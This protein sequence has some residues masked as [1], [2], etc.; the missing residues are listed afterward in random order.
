MSPAF[1]HALLASQGHLDAP[2]VPESLNAHHGF[3]ASK[4]RTP[5]LSTIVLPNYIPE[6]PPPLDPRLSR[7]DTPMIDTDPEDS[8]LDDVWFRSSPI[9]PTTVKRA[10]K[11][12]MKL[13]WVGALLGGM[14]TVSMWFIAMSTLITVL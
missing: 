12:S 10:K 5:T 6:P 4:A 7:N 13:F 11:Q 3:I 9:A 14:L 8:V 1:K 2:P